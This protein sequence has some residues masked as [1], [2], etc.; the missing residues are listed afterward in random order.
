MSILPLSIAIGEYDHVRD[1]LSGQVRAE[2]IDLLSSNLPVEEIFYRFTHFQEWDVSE[3]SFGKYVSLTSQDKNN[4]VAIPVFPSRSFR[5]S[6][7][8][9]RAGGNITSPQQLAGKR[10]GIPEWA[11]TASIY[12]RGYLVDTIGIPLSDIQWV[13][14]GVNEPGRREKVEIRLPAGVSYTAM[15]DHTLNDLLATGEIDAVLSARPPKALTDDTGEIVRLF[16]DYAEVEKQY[17]T[18]TGIFPI[19]HVIAIRRSTFERHPW[20]AMNLFKAFNEA[21]DRSI[22]RALDV[23]ASSFPI[24]W[25]PY[26]ARQAQKMFGGNLW[27]YGIEPNRTTIDAFLRFSFEQGVAH[28][29]L[30]VEDLFPKQVLTSVRV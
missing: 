12:T 28:R 20:I 18:S 4:M 15:P 5:Q 7:M 1:L 14:A 27:D 22:A 17:F 11:Q 29:R 16:D 2:G 19:M 26:M 23:T 13:Q 9:V 3:M 24:P 10:V 21:K 8:Y 6:S 30:A 25:T